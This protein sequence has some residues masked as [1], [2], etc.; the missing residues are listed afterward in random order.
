MGASGGLPGDFTG[1]VGSGSIWRSNLCLEES[2]FL[3]KREKKRKEKEWDISEHQI[4]GLKDELMDIQQELQMQPFGLDLAKKQNRL[5]NTSFK[6][7]S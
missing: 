4:N 5:P 7:C 6:P 1:R 3:L 2:K